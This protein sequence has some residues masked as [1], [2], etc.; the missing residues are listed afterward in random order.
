M[1]M[2]IRNT[3]NKKTNIPGI[4]GSQTGLSIALKAIAKN[5]PADAVRHALQPFRDTPCAGRTVLISA[6]KAGWEMASAA[7]EAM[8]ETDYEGILITK[9]GHIR[10]KLPGFRMFEAGHPVVDENSV[11]AA[12]AAEQVVSCLTRDDRVIVLLSGGASALFEDPVISLPEL[13][14]INRQLLDCGADII[15]INTIRKRLSKVKGGRFAAMCAPAKVHTLILS[16]VLGDRPDMIA[17]GPT[18]PDRST[19]GEAMEIIRRYSLSLSVKAKEALLSPTVAE[20][21]GCSAEIIRGVGALC[22]EAVRLCEA[23]GYRTVF[24]TDS[25]QCEAA[26]AGVFL[27]AIARSNSGKGK[28]LAFIAGGETVVHI[29]GT[30]LGGRNQEMALAAAIGIDG[31]SEVSI[32]CIGSDGTDGPTDA[33]GGTVSGE[34]AGILRSKGLD[35][36]AL[37]ENNDSYHALEAADA[38]IKTGPTGTNVNDL[39]LV[40]IG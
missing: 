18:C 39:A 13:E 35:A 8:S 10:G 17:S 31:L 2:E 27:A 20:L 29:R 14:E 1:I 37:L 23:N 40:L 5:S 33:A 11:L 26:D 9:Y 3:D 21:P 12:R 6:G 19:A 16:D 38:L 4:I 7:A 25:L 30:G 32:L 34:T 15:S 36:R 28:K 24:L 22:S